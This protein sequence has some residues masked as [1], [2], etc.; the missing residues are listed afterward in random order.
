[1]FYSHLDLECDNVRTIHKIQVI[2]ATTTY[3][4]MAC[5]IMTDS[6]IANLTVFDEDING[7]LCKATMVNLS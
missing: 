2:V 1:M 7:E 6:V 5:I 4:S 3:I